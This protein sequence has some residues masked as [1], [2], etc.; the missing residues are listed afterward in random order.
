MKNLLL[1]AILASVS[2]TVFSCKKNKC[3]TCEKIAENQFGTNNDGSYRH[4]STTQL[5]DG[6]IICG[7]E[8]TEY[9][10]LDEWQNDGQTT[11]WRYEC[12]SAK[13]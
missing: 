1:L 13:K 3:G 8:Y 11:R 2:L 6:D 4:E 10:E 5:N 7:D 9:R 12:T